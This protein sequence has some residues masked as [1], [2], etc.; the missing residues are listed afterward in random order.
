MEREKSVVKPVSRNWCFSKNSQLADFS[1]VINLL[2]ILI[3]L[4]LILILFMRFIRKL[5]RP[6]PSTL[7][8]HSSKH[9]ETRKVCLPEAAWGHTI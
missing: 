8:R 7:L 3:I 6:T 2:L 9:M 4:K 5:Q 1:C